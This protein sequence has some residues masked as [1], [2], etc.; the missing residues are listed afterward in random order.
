MLY[1]LALLAA[2]TAAA[3]CPEFALQEPITRSAQLLRALEQ[4]DDDFASVRKEL[5]LV[6][7]APLAG[8]K[9]DPA[10]VRTSASRSTKPRV[11][12]ASAQAGR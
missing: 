1:T 4:A 8:L 10:T 9:P 12:K 11:Q 2:V 7:A 6:G 5:G 3:P